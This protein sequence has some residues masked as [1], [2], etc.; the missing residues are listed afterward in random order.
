MGKL[1]MP[2]AKNSSSSV[3]KQATS[4]TIQDILVRENYVKA[5]DIKKAEEFAKQNHT[6]I[7]EYLLSQGLITKDLLGM[8]ISEF[9]NI[10]Y[11]DLHT[12]Q[13]PLEQVVKIPEDVARKYHIVLGKEDDKTVTVATDNP[14]QANLTLELK[15]IF[16]TKTIVFTYADTE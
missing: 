5:D 4:T 14:T 16:P 9:Y 13:I 10:S 11:A 7:E 15:T 3:P 12:K 2:T 8:A 1:S 6:T